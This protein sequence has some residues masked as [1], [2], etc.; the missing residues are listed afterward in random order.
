MG[1]QWFGL[2]QLFAGLH[3]SVWRAVV[4]IAAFIDPARNLR[5]FNPQ[6]FRLSPLI[7]MSFPSLDPCQMK[8]FRRGS[9]VL[10]LAPPRPPGRSGV[11]VIEREKYEETSV[12]V[13]DTSSA[14]GPVVFGADLGRGG[15]LL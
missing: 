1:L 8:A 2:G 13:G 6:R 15:G 3:I 12:V 4:K 9:L 5:P 14:G 11:L 10:V 7:G